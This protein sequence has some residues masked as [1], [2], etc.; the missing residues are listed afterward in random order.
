MI[1]FCMK[2]TSLYIII[3]C[4]KICVKLIESDRKVMKNDVFDEICVFLMILCVLSMKYYSK[5]L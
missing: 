3:V 2:D 1:R 5:W 4:D